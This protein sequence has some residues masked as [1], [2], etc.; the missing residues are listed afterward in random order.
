MTSLNLSNS[1]K[2]LFSIRQLLNLDLW[3][4]LNAMCKKEQLLMREG[5][6]EKGERER[7]TKT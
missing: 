4:R 7:E 2:S 1:T 5:E 3:Q 6:E